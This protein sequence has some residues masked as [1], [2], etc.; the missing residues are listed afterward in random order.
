MGQC[1]AFYLARGLVG[2]VSHL[3]QKSFA[4]LAGAL[5]TV[6]TIVRARKGEGEEEGEEEIEDLVE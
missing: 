4:Q 3:T 1:R 2:E 5:R 6:N